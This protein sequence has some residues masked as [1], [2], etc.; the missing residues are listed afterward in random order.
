[1]K[2]TR[3]EI[4]AMPLEEK[5]SLS[6]ALWDSIYA[7]SSDLPVPNWHK[8]LLDESLQRLETHPDDNSNWGDIKSRL[9]KTP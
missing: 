2:L 6:D 5:L 7:S 3:A 9:R 1:M 4:D 8:P